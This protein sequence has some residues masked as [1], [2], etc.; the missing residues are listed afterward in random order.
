MVLSEQYCYVTFCKI[1]LQKVLSENKCTT[2]E[3]WGQACP[4]QVSNFSPSKSHAWSHLVT[5]KSYRVTTLKT[6]GKITVFPSSWPSGTL[7]SKPKSQWPGGS[8]LPCC[9]ISSLEEINSRLPSVLKLCNSERLS[10]LGFE[11]GK[12]R[13]YRF[14]N[15]PSPCWSSLNQETLPGSQFER[16]LTLRKLTQIFKEKQF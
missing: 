15:T 8:L 13:G 14:N 4:G 3:A 2:S 6:P 11:G 5:W 7:R 10:S 16:L 9:N 1:A 12:R